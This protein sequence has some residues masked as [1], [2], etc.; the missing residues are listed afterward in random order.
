MFAGCSVVLASLQTGAALATQTNETGTFV[1]PAVPVG[2]YNLKV[3]KDGFRGYELSG[4]RVTVDQRV[5]VNVQL[6]LGAVAQSV[7]IEAS[8][9]ARCWS[10][11]PMS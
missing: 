9:S 8:G 10:R 7:T 1:F 11:H 5:T 4:F 3:V 2:S 6:E